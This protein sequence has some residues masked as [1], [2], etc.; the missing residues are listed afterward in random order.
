MTRSI[1]RM[2]SS[3]AIAALLFG[4]PAMAIEEPVEA[5]EAPAPLKAIALYYHANW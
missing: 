2:L 3:I 1:T 5:V 4:M